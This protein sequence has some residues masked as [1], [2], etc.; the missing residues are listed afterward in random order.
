M[1]A[2]MAMKNQLRHMPL[3]MLNLL[4]SWRLLLGC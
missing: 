1:M 3:K 2:L 4:L